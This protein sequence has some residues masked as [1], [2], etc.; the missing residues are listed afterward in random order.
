MLSRYAG[1]VPA[2]AS[3]DIDNVLHTQVLVEVPSLTV[4]SV[5]SE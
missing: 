2:A 4:R 1:A 3:A 5:A